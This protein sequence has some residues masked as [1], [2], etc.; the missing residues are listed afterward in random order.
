MLCAIVALVS[1]P[2]E[3]RAD[4]YVSPFLG[5]NFANNSG[6]GRSNFGID[7]GWMGAGIAGLELDLGY[8]PNFFGSAGNFG[9]NHVLTAMGNLIVGVPVGGTRGPSVRPYATVGLG[10]INTQ[11]TGTPGANGVPKIA[12]TNF[13]IN[14]GAGVMGFFSDH[15]GLRGDVHYFHDFRNSPPNTVQFGAFHFWRASLG[16]ILR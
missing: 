15:V 8:A 1:A 12:D 13:G 3:A 5:V 2:T 11:V 7:A 10:L 14:G 9:D 4:G 6:D 16:V